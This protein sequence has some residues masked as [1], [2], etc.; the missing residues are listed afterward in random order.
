MWRRTM[1]NEIYGIFVG[2]KLA[3]FISVLV[4]ALLVDKVS[5]DKKQSHGLIIM[6]F[7]FII[8]AAL[9]FFSIIDVGIVWLS[10]DN[11]QLITRPLLGIGAIGLIWYL[12][13]IK[14]NIKQYK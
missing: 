9:E 10:N 1:S 12:I 13:G 6:A 8:I 3:L 11:L 7:A 2:F 4:F 14:K 5:K